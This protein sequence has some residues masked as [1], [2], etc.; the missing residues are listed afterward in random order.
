MTAKITQDEF[1]GWVDRHAPI[2][3]MNS[4]A[5]LRTFAAWFNLFVSCGYTLADLNAATDAMALAPPPDKWGQLEA[6]HRYAR[7]AA[8]GRRQVEKQN[9]TAP[10]VDCLLCRGTGYAMIP[11]PNY[12]D[13]NDPLG[14]TALSRALCWC[15]RGRW[16]ESDETRKAGDKPICI[17]LRELETKVPNW[18]DLMGAYEDFMSARVQ[19][20]AAIAAEDKDE[21]AMRLSASID[22]V[23]QNAT[24]LHATEWKKL[25]GVKV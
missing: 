9:A 19:A 14:F 18:R 22:K 21:K 2:F 23:Q 12:I 15:E 11:H 13:A 24:Q 3:M 5:D 1:N 8:T 6:I 17:T 20:S 16:T 4:D 25:N 10:S 7:R